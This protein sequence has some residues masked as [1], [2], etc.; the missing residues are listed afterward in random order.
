MR[1]KISLFTTA[2][3]R[4]ALY[5]LLAA[6]ALAVILTLAEGLL[7]P[8]LGAYEGDVSAAPSLPDVIDARPL[9]RGL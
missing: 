4:A 6:A 8:S 3:R 5:A 2:E 7:R 1:K 9:S